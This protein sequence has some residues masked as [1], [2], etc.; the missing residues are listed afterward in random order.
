MCIK[1]SGFKSP[2]QLKKEF[3]YEL[4]VNN[5]FVTSVFVKCLRTIIQILQHKLLPGFRTMC[6]SSFKA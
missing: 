3:K 1:Y 2:F 5:N 6:V 4:F